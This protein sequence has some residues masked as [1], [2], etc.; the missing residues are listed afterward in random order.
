MTNLSKDITFFKM[1][2]IFMAT[3]F[4]T[5]VAFAGSVVC[6]IVSA[7]SSV[8]IGDLVSVQVR[9]KYTPATG[10]GSG[11]W[12]VVEVTLRDDDIWPVYNT[13][14]T[15]SSPGTITA[16]TWKPYTF[17]N[18]R[19]SD[20][21]DGG[22]GIELYAHAEVEDWLVNPTG[23]SAIKQV[24]ISYP[25]LYRTPSSLNFGTSTTSMFFTVKNTGGGTLSYIISDNQNWITVNPTSGSCTTETDTINVAVSRSGLAPGSYTGRITIDPSYGSN[26]YVDISMTVPNHS[27]TASRYDP[28]S[29]NITLDYGTTKTFKARGQD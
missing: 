27:P 23:D 8:G 12:S 17:N 19:L 1:L 2:S 22:N 28:T 13:I 11:P 21:D 6:E 5:S 9:I 14:A 4:L 10:D 16:N 20:W 18:V 29:S 25:A 24:S 26:Q 7:P 15:Y 3:I